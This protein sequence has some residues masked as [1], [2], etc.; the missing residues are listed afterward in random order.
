MLTAIQLNYKLGTRI[1]KI[2]NKGFNDALLI[3][4]DRVM[5]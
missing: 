1:V 3:D 4:F 2:S 5:P